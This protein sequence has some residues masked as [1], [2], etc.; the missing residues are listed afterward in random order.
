PSRPARA[1][2][3]MF[4]AALGAASLH[5]S[6]ATRVAALRPYLT[7]DPRP[8]RGDAGAGNSGPETAESGVRRSIRRHMVVGGA[9]LIL[10]TGGMGTWAVTTELSG[11]VIALGHLVVASN[12]KAVQH[13]TGGT[14]GA[15][16]VRDGDRV[17][18]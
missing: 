8:A 7:P 10:L 5:R 15:I 12:V 14:V 11:A 18:A 4:G 16:H 13:P 1:A 17:E 3:A 6:L 9:A 2:G